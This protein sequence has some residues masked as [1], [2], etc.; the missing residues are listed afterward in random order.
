[1]DTQQT[2]HH[3]TVAYIEQAL[4]EVKLLHDPA[5]IEPTLTEFYIERSRARLFGL[6]PKR[7]R[8]RPRVGMKPRAVYT[9]TDESGSPLGDPIHEDDL[10]EQYAEAVIEQVIAA[11]LAAMLTD[12]ADLVALHRA[13]DGGA[14]PSFR[15]KPAS[16]LAERTDTEASLEKQKT[17][18]RDDIMRVRQEQ[19]D[20]RNALNMVLRQ[21]RE[22]ETALDDAK[23]N[24][25]GV[26]AK[27]K[28]AQQVIDRAARIQQREALKRGP[29]P[30]PWE[31]S[32]A[33]EDNSLEIG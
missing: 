9:V 12:H 32:P 2:I 22:A 14:A 21:Q 27:A 15:Y 5:L 20:A 24:T 11:N 16:A 3:M 18:L 23:R 8:F 7:G 10:G 29:L 6:A 17:V 13:G 1:M 33:T 30:T 26:V 31:D 19:E 28:E 4:G 25:S